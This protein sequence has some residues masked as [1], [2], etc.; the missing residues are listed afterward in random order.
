MGELCPFEISKSSNMICV[1]SCANQRH[2]AI[3]KM[4]RHSCSNTKGGQPGAH[5]EC[6]GKHCKGDQRIFRINYVIFVNLPHVSL[7]AIVHTDL[8]ATQWS[9]SLYN[10]VDYSDQAGHD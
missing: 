1:K 3:S 10:A 8:I 7:Y 6:C 4:Y 9:F 5:G 2:A